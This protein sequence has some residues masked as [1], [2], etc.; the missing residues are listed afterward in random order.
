[1]SQGTK[2][3]WCRDTINPWVGC[4]RVSPACDH[5]YAAIYAKRF[6]PQAA[7]WDGEPVRARAVTIQK[8][9][10]V[11]KRANKPRRVFCGSMTDLGLVAQRDPDGLAGFLSDLYRVQTARMQAGRQPHAFLWLT[12]R[13]KPLARFFGALLFEPGSQT[14]LYKPKEQVPDGQHAAT[15]TL[16][17]KHVPGLWVGV[18][19]ENQP[20]AD[21]RVPALLEMDLP[22]LLWVSVEPILGAV[23]LQTIHCSDG[24][25]LDARRGHK[26]GKEGGQG[27]PTRKLSWIVVGG[28]TGALARPSNPA[29][30]HSLRQHAAA[31]WVPF[32][33]KSWGA[34]G[35]IRP[36]EAGAFKGEVVAWMGSDMVIQV[37]TPH[38]TM[39]YP[40]VAKRGSK[41]NDAANWVDVLDQDVPEFPS[42]S[43]DSFLP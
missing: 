31:I 11:L 15:G 40:M 7:R 8:H 34:W 25:I 38:P 20:M 10:D 28:E 12:K 16:I 13:P 42:S 21:A 35:P 43:P 30:A 27:T 36:E 9:L 14:F 19:A 2:I 17:T 6:F 41:R 24:A 5:C 1:M 39:N 29:W 37:P 4:Q 23:N 3:K 18:T 26:T 32:F 33:F 22:E